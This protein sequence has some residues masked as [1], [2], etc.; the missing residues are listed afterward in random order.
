M[1][2][3]DTVIFRDED[4][5]EVEFKVLDYIE[6]D[7]AEY[8]IVAAPETDQEAFILRVETG[9]DGSD[10]Y[11]TIEDDDEW[12]TVAEAYEELLE[13]DEDWD[14]DEED[15]DGGSG[16]FDDGGDPDDDDAAAG[17]LADDDDDGN[18]DLDEFLDDDGDDYDDED[19][20]YD[21]DGDYDD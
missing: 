7:D 9:E 14:D 10:T 12:E 18:L 2:G 15:D 8:V 20:D 1:G 6:V 21:G 19:D 3:L 16:G 5:E 13:E 11:I 17:F 4:G